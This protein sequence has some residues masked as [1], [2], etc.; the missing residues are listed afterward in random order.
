MRRSEGAGSLRI[1]IS[2]ALENQELARRLKV[3][4]QRYGM[5]VFVDFDGIIPGESLPAR[6]NNGLEWCNTLV[7]LWSEHAA[8]SHYVSAE[9]AAA[10][11]AGRRIIPC[12]LDGTHLPTLLAHLLYVPF[13]NYKLDYP[14]LCKACARQ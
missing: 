13:S 8:R 4:L 6:I 14:K 11:H 1:F 2:Y 7:L 10:F 9:W 5:E 3:D 12:K